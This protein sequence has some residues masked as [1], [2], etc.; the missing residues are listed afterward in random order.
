MGA[1]PP[2]E[3]KQESHTQISSNT[4]LPTYNTNLKSGYGGSVKVRRPNDRVHMATIKEGYP[5]FP[6][7]ASDSESGLDIIKVQRP[8]DE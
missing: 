8:T 7:Y 4:A 2:V 3:I 5:T 6:N 1:R